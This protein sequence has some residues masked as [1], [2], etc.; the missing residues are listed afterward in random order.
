MISRKHMVAIA[1]RFNAMLKE[2]DDK[3]WVAYTSPA[4]NTKWKVL[5]ELVGSRLTLDA[6]IVGE[7]GEGG[8]IARWLAEENP[9]FDLDRFV[10]A[11]Y[12]GVVVSGGGLGDKI[13]ERSQQ[14]Y[15][16]VSDVN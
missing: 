1:G 8:V 10:S 11:C 15:K 13:H 3:Y 14:M 4:D 12:D 2:L 7:H 5:E 9:N 16:V 6:L